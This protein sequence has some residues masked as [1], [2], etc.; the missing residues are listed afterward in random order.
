MSWVVDTCVILDIFCGDGAFAVESAEALDAK[1]GEGLSIAPVT[2]VEL[3]PSFNGNA[4]EQDAVLEELG[5]SAD[6]GGNRNQILSAHKAWNE[7]VLRKRDGAERKR[8]IA[9]IL[10]GAY[11]LTKGGLITRNESDFRALYPS[12]RILNP[13][14]STTTT[15]V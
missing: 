4:A 6:F 10:I 5:I 2:Y 9:D 13:T 15:P 3:S 11:A 12:L 8:P 7:H 1:R 14:N